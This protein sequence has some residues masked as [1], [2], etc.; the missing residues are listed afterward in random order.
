MTSGGDSRLHRYHAKSSDYHRSRCCTHTLTIK[1][2]TD[3][4]ADKIVKMAA[5]DDQ[6][7]GRA[8]GDPRRPVKIDIAH[9]GML[10]GRLASQPPY[11][12]LQLLP[13]A[14]L[15]GYPSG[16]ASVAGLSS[17]AR[18]VV[19]RHSGGFVRADP[20]EASRQCPDANNGITHQP[21]GNTKK[22]CC[23]V[24]LHIH[25]TDKFLQLY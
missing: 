8:S 5:D 4:T 23:C 10:L 11:R 14:R 7:L 9:V 1:K 12:D 25:A 2:Q 21:R 18:S 6:T 16:R 13:P 3:V 19:G 22:P 15:S 20:P 24:C 17:A